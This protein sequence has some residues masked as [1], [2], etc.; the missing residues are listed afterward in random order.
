MSVKHLKDIRAG[1]ERIAGGKATRL[2]DLA[3]AGHPVPAGFVVLAGRELSDAEILRTYDQLELN[4]VAVR[5]SGI[6]ED[7]TNQSWAGQFETLLHVKRDNLLEAIQACID[8]VNTARAKA[9]AD[10]AMFDLAVLVQQM[11]HSDVAG[12]AFSANPV[13]GNAD[14]IVIEAVY[15]LGELLVQGT[16]TPDLYILSKDGRIIEQDIVHKPTF[17]TH[18]GGATVEAEVPI[19]KQNESALSLR[20]LGEIAELVKRVE[21]HYGYPVD[22]EWAYGP[23]GNVYLLQARPITTLQKEIYG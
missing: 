15:G 3:Q 12:V 20:Q 22:I 9:Y 4:N 7:G 21:A 19:H 5:S 6:G 13:D 11:I 16:V 2:G 10:G 8:S 17:L 1:D 14:H 23:D 18:H